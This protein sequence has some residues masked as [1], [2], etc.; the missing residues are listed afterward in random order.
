MLDYINNH[1]LNMID[2]LQHVFD[3][4]EE[5]SEVHMILEKKV[6]KCE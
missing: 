1:L 4:H 5:C 2:D 6:D 3:K